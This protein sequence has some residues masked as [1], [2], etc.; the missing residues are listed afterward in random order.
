M[1]LNTSGAL[2]HSD[3]REA[4]CGHPESQRVAFFTLETQVRT[5]TFGRETHPILAEMQRNRSLC[6]S[7]PADQGC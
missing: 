5:P 1:V 4:V 2:C 3:S 6:L 7:P